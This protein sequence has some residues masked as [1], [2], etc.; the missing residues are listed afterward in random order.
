MNL[1]FIND[2]YIPIVFVFCLCVGYL[3]KN[4]FPTDNKYI[5]TAMFIIGCI[6]GVIC[7]GPSFT[8]VVKGGV[9]G[10][11]STGFHQIFKQLI[12]NP[13]AGG[14]KSSNYSKNHEVLDP[15]DNGEEVQNG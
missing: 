9:T 12:E 7:L 2:Y 8:A 11:A 3:L 1:D 15:S 6:C 10:L 4:L 5:P 13:K 14:E